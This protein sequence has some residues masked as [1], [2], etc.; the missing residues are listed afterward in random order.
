MR[1]DRAEHVAQETPVVLERYCRPDIQKVLEMQGN[2]QEQP[3]NSRI[4]VGLRGTS[5]PPI[6]LT[7]RALQ[8]LVIGSA[9]APVPAMISSR[10]SGR[11]TRYTH[12]PNINCRRQ[13]GY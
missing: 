9:A 5:L 8:R 4:S 13:A 11:V 7:S 6:R 10:S 2:H 1:V 3:P 12:L